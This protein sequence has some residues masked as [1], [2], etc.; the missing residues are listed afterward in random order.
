MGPIILL[1]DSSSMLYSQSCASVAIIGTTPHGDAQTAMQI[2]HD[3]GFYANDT[4]KLMARLVTENSVK[5]V[6]KE[7][8]TCNTIAHWGLASSGASRSGMSSFCTHFKLSALVLSSGEKLLMFVF[9]VINIYYD[10]GFERSDSINPNARE[11]ETNRSIVRTRPSL[12]SSQVLEI[13]EEMREMPDIGYFVA[14]MG[15]GRAFRYMSYMSAMAN[16]FIILYILSLGS[17][18]GIPDLGTRYGVG[19]SSAFELFGESGVVEPPNGWVL[20]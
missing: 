1:N 2:L 18:S 8:S 6:G 14:I 5:P 19:A 15:S 13:S 20:R 7:P 9:L 17:S 4:C 3:N 10:V 12:R 16:M 11:V